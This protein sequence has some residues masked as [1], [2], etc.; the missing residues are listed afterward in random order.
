MVDM[1]RKAS[2]RDIPYRI[3]A[4]RPGDIGEAV[5]DVSLIE[6]TMG[7]K[8]KRSVKEA[9]ESSWRFVNNFN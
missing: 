1:A 6:K 7:W 2:G 4:R 3:A 9:V 5:A 8:A